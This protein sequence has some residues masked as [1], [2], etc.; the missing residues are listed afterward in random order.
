MFLLTKFIKAATKKRKTL[1]LSLQLAEIDK[2]MKRREEEKEEDREEEEEEMAEKKEKEAE[3]CPWPFANL[4]CK[5]PKHDKPGPSI[6]SWS[7]IAK[8]VTLHFRY[9]TR[10]TQTRETRPDAQP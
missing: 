7:R 10:T 3:S 1:N 6:L 9:P 2:Q 5:N 8:H 4:K